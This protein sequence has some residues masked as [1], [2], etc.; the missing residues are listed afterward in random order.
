MYI[1]LVKFISTLY[2]ILNNYIL[3]AVTFSLKPKEQ[4]QRREQDFI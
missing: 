3:Y 1:V 4:K 2:C